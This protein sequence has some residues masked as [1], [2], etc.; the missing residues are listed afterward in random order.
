[1]AEQVAV[2]Q[3]GSLG[4]SIVSLPALRAIRE[5]LPECSDYILVSR[6]DNNTYVLPA[7]VFDMVWKAKTNI[8]FLGQ[9]SAVRK[10]RSA[11]GAIRQLRRYRPR[12]CVSLMPSP[13]TPAQVRRDALFFRA[14]GVREL[15]G[16]RPMSQEELRETSIGGALRRESYL[17]FKRL[18]G[19][20]AAHEFSR[21]AALPLL[22]PDAL[23]VSAVRTWLNLRGAGQ[24][25]LLVAV[26]P[27]SNLAARDWPI[28]HVKE[29]IARLAPRADIVVVGGAKDK[30]RAASLFAAAPYAI[31]A[32]GAFQVKESAALLSLCRLAITVD[33][34]P[35]H[36][37]S[38]V[39]TDSLVILSRYDEFG[40]WLPL[41]TGH[42]VLY[43][44]VPCAGCRQPVCPLSGHPCMS[45]ISVDDVFDAALRKLGLAEAAPPRRTSTNILTL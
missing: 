14:A 44:D 29:L 39:G 37:A 11:A 3:I 30:E 40:R 24:G 7:S 31:D 16:F 26:C 41:G 43:R 8:N 25:R 17:R 9:V 33:S 38:A 10:L 36:L 20:N 18:A 22:A 28:A 32:C 45:Q 1:L 19:E 2:F 42:T 5:R 35:T 15:I 34:G 4:D 27:F 13:R 6:Y 21:Y 23:N 12:Y